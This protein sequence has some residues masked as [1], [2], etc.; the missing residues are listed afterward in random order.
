MDA[1]KDGHVDELR[2]L[3]RKIETDIADAV[4]EQNYRRADELQKRLGYVQSKMIEAEGLERES[5]SL[6]QLD[7]ILIAAKSGVPQLWQSTNRH[8]EIAE[9]QTAPYSRSDVPFSR[10]L[11]HACTSTT[12]SGETVV[13]DAGQR[14][15]LHARVLCAH[16]QGVLG[17]AQTRHVPHGRV[18][19]TPP[20]LRRRRGRRRCC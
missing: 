19:D 15:L 17:P 10:A 6:A 18:Q 20:Q 13:N 11:A 14:V 4:A 3:E 2:S 5:G 8:D 12:A 1:P 7:E 9:M 16:R